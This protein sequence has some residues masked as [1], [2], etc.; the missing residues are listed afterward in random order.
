MVS[1]SIFTAALTMALTACGGGGGGNSNSTSIDDGYET[2]ALTGS[3]GDGPVINAD[4]FIFDSEGG[5]M[6]SHKSDAFANYSLSFKAKGNPFPI[7][8][9]AIR[10]TDLVTGMRPDFTLKSVSFSRS[11]KRVNL[12]PFTTLIVETARAMPGGFTQANV[13]TASAIV[14]REMNFGLDTS[15]IPSPAF[16]EITESN[17]ANIVRSS[18]ALGE[19]MRRTRTG[20]A[21]AGYIRPHNDIVRAIAADIADGRLDGQGAAGMDARASAVASVAATQILVEQF[22][23]RLEV[24]GTSAVAAMDS[25]IMQ[26]LPT[27]PSNAL[28]SSVRIPQAMV[29]QATRLLNAV[30]SV[31]AR[32]EV[33]ALRQSVAAIP[34]G[35]T[36]QAARTVLAAGASRLFDATITNVAQADDTTLTTLAAALTT[37]DG[38]APEPDEAVDPEPESPNRAPTIGGTPATAATV[39][40]AYVFTPSSSDADGDRLVFSILNRPAWAAF[41]TSTGRLSGTPSSS[42]AGTYTDIRISVSDGTSATTLPAFNIT[43]GHANRAPTISGQPQG[44]VVATHAYSFT[45]SA[46]D[47]DGDTLTFSIQN[48][49]G[50]AAFNTATGRLSGTPSN[51]QVGQYSNIRIRVSDGT[52]STAL[53]AF[54]ITVSAYVAPNRAPSIT[55]TP[56]ASVNQGAAYTFTPSASDADGD[57]LSFSIVN[58]PGWM[59]FNS[60]TGR[61]SGTPSNSHVGTYSNIVIRVSDGTASASL[62]AFSVTVVNVNDAPGISGAPA[63]SVDAGSAYAFTPAAMDL[64]GDNLTFS[65]TNRPAW[66]SFN[67]ATGRLSGTPTESNVGTYGNIVIRVSDGQASAQLAPFSISVNSAEPVSRDV[68]LGWVAPATRADGSA[69]SL[70]QIA[71]FR[72]RYGTSAGNY[73]SSVNVSD[74]SATTHTIQGMAPATYYFVVTAIDVDGQESEYSGA[75]NTTVH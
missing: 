46:S 31:D 62:P 27:T 50:W 52:T 15:T 17:I 25:S 54:G 7:T 9:E 2:F 34:A 21:L 47:A 24:N 3:V 41:S 75:V 6:A 43:V 68:T 20:L 49:P 40:N 66:A 65:I 29:T 59:S 70:S 14:I 5:L 36:T 1:K 28:T 12:N 42:H 72:I 57:S 53:P 39:G 74:P 23:N 35:S 4:I 13:E 10:G 56:A 18:E 61:L 69:L 37:A 73:T 45:P 71:S 30:A 26:T 60:T 11:Q 55:G 33:A 51:A 64:D 67:S 8:L 58:R 48:R 38:M 63:T 44:A 32:P 22:Q 16:T 19:L